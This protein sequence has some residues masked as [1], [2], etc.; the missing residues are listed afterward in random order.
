[1][2]V[3]HLNESTSLL[4]LVEKSSLHEYNDVITTVHAAS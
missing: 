4:F 3:T 1:M 2:N